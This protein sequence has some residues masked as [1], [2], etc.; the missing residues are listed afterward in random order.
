MRVSVGEIS[1]VRRVIRLSLGRVNATVISRVPL[2]T[3]ARARE[4]ERQSLFSRSL[5]RLANFFVQNC[6]TRR[7]AARISS[8]AS[9]SEKHAVQRDENLRKNSLGNYKSADL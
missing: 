7:N 8:G 3:R 2:H 5:L 6:A 9:R 4:R 1:E